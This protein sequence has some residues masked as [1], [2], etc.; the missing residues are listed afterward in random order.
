M[1]TIVEEQM[2]TGVWNIVYQPLGFL[3]FLFV[4]LL[5]ATARLSIYL[6]QKTN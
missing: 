1:K 3:I 6:K 5:N 2:K 4:H